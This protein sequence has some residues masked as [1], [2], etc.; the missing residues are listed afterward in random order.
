MPEMTPDAMEALA[1]TVR[2]LRSLLEDDLSA[3]LERRYR[4]SVP[5]VAAGLDESRGFARARFEAWL[6]ERARARRAAGEMARSEARR[7]A[8]SEAAARTLSRLILLRQLEVC[9]LSRPAVLTNGR[10]SKA[11]RELSAHAPALV[12]DEFDG[13]DLLLSLVFEELAVDMPGVF[14]EHPLDRYFTLS[15]AAFHEVVA[16]LNAP[17]LQSAWQDDTALGWVY[18]FWNDPHREAIDQRIGPRG[19]VELHEI[20]S[21]TQLFTERYMVD[22]LLQNSVGRIAERMREKRLAQ[23]ERAPDAPSPA[24]HWPMF[25]RRAAKVD[26]TGVPDEL[27]QLRILDPA[28]GSGHFLAGAFDLLVQLYR[29]EAADRGH[30]ISDEE[31][32]DNIVRHNLHGVDIDPRAVQ[33]A[34]AVLYLKARRLAQGGAGSGGA[35]PAKPVAPMNLV[36]TSFDLDRLRPGDRAL[37]TLAHGLPGGSRQLAVALKELANVSFRGSLVRFGKSGDDAD[38]ERL[39]SGLSR[40]DD[41]GLRFDGSQL[42]AGLRLKAILVDGRYDVVAFNP[43]YLATSKIQ[44]PPRALAEAFGEAPDMFAAFVDRAL[45]L[46]KPTG[47]IAFVAL[48]NWMYLA[49][50]RTVRERLLKSHLLLV[51]DIGKG[52]FRR[53]SKLIQ[54]AMVVASPTRLPAAGCLAARIG[55]RDAIAM[56]Q[57]EELALELRDESIYR[58]FDPDVFASIEGTP[59]LFW[60]E[61]GFLRRYRQLPKIGEVARAAGGIATTNNDRFLRAVWEVSPR[62]VRAAL[63]GDVSAKHKPYIKGAEG[64]EWIEPCRW[65][66]RMERDG[67]ELRM[68]ASSG[69]LD[70]VRELGVAYTTIGQ[71]FGA[72]LHSVASVRDVSGASIFPDT[73]TNAA[74]LVCALN[75][76]SVRELA[77]GLNPTINFQLGDVRRLPFDPVESA[78]E[79]VDVLRRELEASERASELS[80]SYELPIPHAWQHAQR[81]AQVAVDRSPGDPLPVEAFEREPV[82]P[83]LRLSHE[84]GVALGRF[85]AS[86]GWSDRDGERGRREHL[87]FIGPDGLAVDGPHHARLR[88][89]WTEV[90]PTVSDRD[91]SSHLRSAFFVRHLKQYAGRPIHFPLSSSKRSFVAY[92][93][94]HTL[95]NATLSVLL[96]DYLLVEQRRL[97]G[98]LAD[99]TMARAGGERKGETDRRRTEIRRLLDELRDFVA[100]VSEVAERGPPRPENATPAREVDTRFVV[101]RDDGVMMT[102]ASLWSLLE[103]QWREPR[104]WW[105]ELAEGG[106]KTDCDWSKLAARYFPARV[107]NKCRTDPSLAAAHGRL[108]KLHPN[109]V[110]ARKERPAR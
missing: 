61:P 89:V 53:A 19:K 31:I 78:G 85:D 69:K 110:R 13:F 65:L 60:L 103:S 96:S 38:I 51:A 81:W 59:L 16:A 83:W 23:T 76:T 21:K 26:E 55:S 101:D 109:K 35:R 72:R 8:E 1:T 36:A 45:E 102:S 100:K 87:L 47:L 52:A 77:S 44:A 71:R 7:T 95:T 63:E 73:E 30:A 32:A 91:L 82:D 33:V 27:C 98:E 92:V 50:Y 12:D 106:T 17:A 67:A 5:A 37:T 25:V 68:L 56:S 62:L 11:Y 70:E 39:L 49:T 4:L 22:W 108:A 6:D 94:F 86:G 74:S 80:P 84:V 104:K 97:E 41:L 2:R 28:C 29:Q 54:T 9:G 18:Q 24:L 99:L 93:C 79:I 48:S 75:R 90:R 58:P 57:P 14:G 46:C 66:L 40:S 10:S 3:Q 15:P 88:E 64:R 105:R 20:A 34:A 42:E 107:R 43:P